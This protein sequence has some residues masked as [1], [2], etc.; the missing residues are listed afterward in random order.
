VELAEVSVAPAPFHTPA[1]VLPVVGKQSE[2]HE[3][4]QRDE[5]RILGQVLTLL[6]QLR[7]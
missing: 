5:Q 1:A 3:R 4:D 7:E 6:A 2:C